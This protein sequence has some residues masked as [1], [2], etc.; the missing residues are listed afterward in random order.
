MTAPPLTAKAATPKNSP[1]AITSGVFRVDAT[2]AGATV[3]FD[4]DSSLKCAAP[5]SMTLPAGRHTFVVQMA[6]Y[7]DAYRIID[8]PHDTGL[9]V[10]LDKMSGML[11]LSTNPSGLTIFIDG[12]EQPR[13]SPASFNLAP[14]PHTIEVVKGSER[15][16]VPVEIHDGATIERNIDL[17]Q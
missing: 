10:N 9:I 3:T 8:I 1:P 2:P 16:K 15:H 5:C 12:Q 11:T 7:R 13:K 4:R 6:G 14:G 17:S